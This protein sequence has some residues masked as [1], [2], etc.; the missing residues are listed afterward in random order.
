MK[1]F[2]TLLERYLF[3]IVG[4]IVPGLT[5]AILYHLIVNNNT[6]TELIKQLQT[7]EYNIITWTAIIIVLYILGMFV[8]VIAIKTYEIMGSAFGNSNDCSIPRFFKRCANYL[9][10]SKN[11]CLIEFLEQK[12]ESET[13]CVCICWFMDNIILYP[14]KIFVRIFV[15]ILFNVAKL[16][17]IATTFKIDRCPY[18]YK[19]LYIE[20]RKEMKEQDIANFDEARDVEEDAI[21][22]YKLSSVIIRQNEL[23]ALF[24]NFLAKYN[25]FRSLSLVFG[26]FGLYSLF[27]YKGEF[28][29]YYTICLLI[30]WFVFHYKYIRYWG[31]CGGDAISTALI[32]LKAHKQQ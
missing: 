15:G 22:L 19:S 20:L 11:N 29:Q 5:S 31:L 27:F 2:I 23:K 9:D 18:D 28:A 13:S 6:P 4:V 8:K 25:L 1:N 10:A 7:M 14:I 3:D 21:Q 17:E 24:D 16:L 12:N 32:Y 30:A 26:A